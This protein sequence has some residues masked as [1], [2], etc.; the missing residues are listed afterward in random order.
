MTPEIIKTLLSGGN[1]DT[2]GH[3]VSDDERQWSGLTSDR[4]A[5]WDEL[6][7]PQG[8]PPGYTPP[9][10]AMTSTQSPTGLRLL[11]ALMII[12]AAVFIWALYYGITTGS[13]EA[14]T[15]VLC[16]AMSMLCIGMA[17]WGFRL[18]NM[19]ANWLREKKQEE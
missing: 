17:I 18:A 8:Q 16:A 1:G 13:F 5:Q 12:G 4:P 10:T 15:Y 3:V 19:R 2:G 9:G 14:E 11:S 7:G 6:Y